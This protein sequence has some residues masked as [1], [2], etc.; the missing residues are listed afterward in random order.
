MRQ[1]FKYQGTVSCFSFEDNGYKARVN[2]V[3]G[4]VRDY[5]KAPTRIEAFGGLANYINAIEMTDAEERYIKADWYYDSNLFL[6]RIEIPTEDGRIAK[7]I[8]QDEVWADDVV[9][10]G[11]KDYVDTDSPVPMGGNQFLEWSVYRQGVLK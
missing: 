6:H 7:I 9:I 2:M 4:D 10:F 5:G 3:L 1:L 8:T 11:P